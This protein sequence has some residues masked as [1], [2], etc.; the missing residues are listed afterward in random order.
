MSDGQKFYWVLVDM[1]PNRSS[2]FKFSDQASADKTAEEA[3]QW[4]KVTK[5]VVGHIDKIMRY[6]DQ[7]TLK[8][9]E[10][11]TTYERTS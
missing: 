8:P 7:P 6:Y 5:I 2:I 4:P 11:V 10:G 1:G 9:L 3:K